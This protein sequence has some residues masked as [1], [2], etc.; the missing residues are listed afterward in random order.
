MA[1]TTWQGWLQDYEEDW[2]PKRCKIETYS[3]TD[4]EHM[5]AVYADHA[6]SARDGYE[7]GDEFE[8]HLRDP[9]GKI[10]SFDIYVE[11]VPSFRA[12]CITEEKS[13]GPA[14]T[15]DE[16]SQCPS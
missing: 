6:Y 2:E 5:A 15:A 1:K 7:C 9:D 4:L 8:V 16:E 11:H 14:P 3:T 12:R 13:D 10:H